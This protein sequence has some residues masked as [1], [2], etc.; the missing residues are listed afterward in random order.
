MRLLTMSILFALAIASNSEAQT[1][2]YIQYEKSESSTS[3][4]G[5]VDPL[6]TYYTYSTVTV[7]HRID[8]PVPGGGTQRVELA[9]QTSIHPVQ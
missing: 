8:C 3:C 1:N 7:H 5:Y 2:S 9:T 6:G 4:W